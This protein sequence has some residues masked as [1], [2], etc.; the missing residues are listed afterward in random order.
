M[1][2]LKLISMIIFVGAVNYVR[3][4]KLLGLDQSPIQEKS[5]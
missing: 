1:K 3:T 4:Q 2:I 5:R